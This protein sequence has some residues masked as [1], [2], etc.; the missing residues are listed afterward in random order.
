MN[1]KKLPYSLSLS[2]QRFCA[3]KMMGILSA[4][5]IKSEDPRKA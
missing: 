1:F 2:L 3:L 4:L 5:A